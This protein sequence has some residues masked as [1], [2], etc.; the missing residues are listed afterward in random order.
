VIKTHFTA[1][2]QLILFRCL[3]QRY[4]M[5]VGAVTEKH[6]PDLVLVG[7]FKSHHLGPKFCATFDI[8]DAQH[9]VA[10][11]FDFDRRLFFSH[12]L[13]PFLKSLLKQRIS[14]TDDSSRQN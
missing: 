8:A 2:G 6:H 11:F 9:H 5:M 1:L 10:D 7:K 12:K 4:G 14:S 3:H 13:P